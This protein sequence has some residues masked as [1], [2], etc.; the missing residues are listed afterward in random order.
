[1]SLTMNCSSVITSTQKEDLSKDVQMI[2][3][4]VDKGQSVWGTILLGTI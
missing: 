1:M 2:E 4:A 3:E